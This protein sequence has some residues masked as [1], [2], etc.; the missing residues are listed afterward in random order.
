[1]STEPTTPLVSMRNPVGLFHLW[2]VLC[3]DWEVHLSV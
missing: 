3:I 1:M 2:S